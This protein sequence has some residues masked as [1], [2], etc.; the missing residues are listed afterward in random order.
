MVWSLVKEV[1]EKP[2]VCA[3]FTFAYAFGFF[4]LTFRDQNMYCKFL[5]I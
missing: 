3:Y 2:D 1:K 5:D 4:F